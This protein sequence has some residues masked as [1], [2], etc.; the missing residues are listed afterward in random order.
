MLAKMFTLAQAQAVYGYLLRFPY[1]TTIGSSM[2]VNIQFWKD[3][4]AKK[5]ALWW[6]EHRAELAPIAQAP[7]L[8]RDDLVWKKKHLTTEDREM[9]LSYEE[10]ELIQEIREAFRNSIRPKKE[11][12]FKEIRA[13]IKQNSFFA[14]RTKAFEETFRPGM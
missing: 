2:W 14:E 3:Q 11:H 1:D 9:M 10:K 5:Q 13:P 6:K 4:V 8:S 12:L 7:C